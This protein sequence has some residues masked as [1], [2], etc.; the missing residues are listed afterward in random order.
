MEVVDMKHMHLLFSLSCL[1]SAMAAESLATDPTTSLPQPD[2]RRDT[3]NLTEESQALHRK[4]VA[5]ANAAVA[6]A[7]VRAEKDPKRPGYHFQAPALWMNDPN[8]PIFYKDEYHLFYQQNPYGE[9]WGHMHWGRAT[10]RD[11][12]H[13][14]HLPIA[15]AP[16][17]DKGEEHCFSG[18]A[19]VH[20]GMP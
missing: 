1:L 8:G 18:C 5:Q 10:S 12:V 20:N 6:K 3:G 11:L 7:G 9:K 19:V 16:S 15:L 13:W 14:Q 2:L 17:S 4:L